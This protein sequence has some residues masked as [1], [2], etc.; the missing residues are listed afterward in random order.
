MRSTVLFRADGSHDIGLGHIMRCIAFAQSFEN[1]G[2]EAIFVIRNYDQEVNKLIQKNGYQVESI[3]CNSNYAEDGALT[4]EFAA[5]HG[6]RVIITDLSN[7]YTFTNLNEFSGYLQM[8]K[9]TSIFSIGID[10]FGEE[11]IST[12]ISLPFDIVV[13]PYF[14][15]E[16]E[17]YKS[18]TNTK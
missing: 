15:A 4:L 11:G 2:V 14:G 13:I 7:K 17:K 5:R 6:A 1:I 18:N 10:G 16:K 12:K 9:D 8:L 3:P